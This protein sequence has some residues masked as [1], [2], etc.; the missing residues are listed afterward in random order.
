[1]VQEIEHFTSVLDTAIPAK[2]LA[3]VD[4]AVD[5]VGGELRECTEDFPDRKDTS[6]GG[7]VPERMKARAALKGL[8]LD[9][10]RIDAAASA[11]RFD[12]ASQELAAYRQHLAD[13]VPLMKAAEPW[14]LFNP[15]VRVAHYMAMRQLFQSA[16][17]QD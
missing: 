11:G 2:N 16:K 12:E 5:T 13:A 1:Q 8:V 17:S 4:L 3:V 15:P 7:G 9:L 14:S 6:V 10:R